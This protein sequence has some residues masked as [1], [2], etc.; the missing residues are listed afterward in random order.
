[1]PSTASDAAEAQARR[2]RIGTGVMQKGPY[3]KIRMKV[4]H[5]EAGVRLGAAR[6]TPR[7]FGVF[8]SPGG[9]NLASLFGLAR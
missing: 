5:V 1:M 7:F 2:W 6:S 4:I 3:G 8:L 9:Y